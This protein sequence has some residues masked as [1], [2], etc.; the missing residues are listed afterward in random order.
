M[1]KSNELAGLIKEMEKLT[2]EKLALEENILSKL[3]DQLLNN[4]AARYMHK[5]IREVKEN[6]RN[7]VT[8]SSFYYSYIVLFF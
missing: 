6:N 1:I 3:E 5:L 2:S 8:K 7:L 4:K